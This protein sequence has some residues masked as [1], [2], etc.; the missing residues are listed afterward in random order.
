MSISNL[1]PQ[2]PD[3]LAVPFYQ[4]QGWHQVLEAQNIPC[5]RFYL[6]G[7]EGQI[8]TLVGAYTIRGITYLHIPRGPIISGE[9]TQKDIRLWHLEMNR[10]AAEYNA[11]WCTIDLDILTEEHEDLLSS[12]MRFPNSPLP[13][14]TQ[15]LDLRKSPDTLLSEMHKKTRYNIRRAQAKKVTVTTHTSHDSDF[16][17]QLDL[18]YEICQET[19]DRAQFHLHPKD[20]YQ[21]LLETHTSSFYPILAQA[22]HENDTLASHLYLQTDTEMIYLHGGSRCLKRNYMAPSYLQWHMI[23]QG[24]KDHLE[25]FDFWGTSDTIASWHGITRF[26]RR[27][28]GYTVNYPQSRALIYKPLLASLYKL[29]K[30]Y[31]G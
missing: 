27:F 21:T 13:R 7:L 29:Y 3:H 2:D 14:Q 19:A 17:H 9:L 28:G 1:S 30:Q 25:T 10:Q 18:F 16:N 15:K 11:A 24:C 22:H 31:K 4:S 12:S 6:T 26:K 23:T 8:Q 5:S 20:H